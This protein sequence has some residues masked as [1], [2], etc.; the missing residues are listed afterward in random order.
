MNSDTYRSFFELATASIEEIDYKID[1]QDRGT[2]TVIVGIHGG[3]IEPHTE[4]LVTLVANPDI[5]YYLFIGNA[6]KQHITS[7]RFDEPRCLALLSRHRTVVSIH[8]KSGS[9]E[10]VMLG[11]LDEILVDKAAQALTRAG[12]DVRI[13]IVNVTGADVL[14][15]CN[16]GASGKGLQLE[17]SRGLREAL[18]RNSENMTDFARCIREAILM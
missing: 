4:L 9:E 5:S 8:G 12:F 16:K 11:G 3:E 14:N 10:F 13:P 6:V 1:L 2:S 17:M 18:V 7:T 15:I